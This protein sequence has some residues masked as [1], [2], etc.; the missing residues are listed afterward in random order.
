MTEDRHGIRKDVFEHNDLSIDNWTLKI[1]M[2]LLRQVDN[3]AGIERA[4]E[5]MDPIIAAAANAP[6]QPEKYE[7]GSQGPKCAEKLATMGIHLPIDM[8]EHV[9]A[10]A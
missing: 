8:F 5:I 6:Q 10:V 2:D 7:V 1:P 9:H 3:D 4:W